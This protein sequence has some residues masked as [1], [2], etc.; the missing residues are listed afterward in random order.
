[1]PGDT[2]EPFAGWA[3]DPDL[4]AAG[5][6]YRAER[7]AEAAAYE[8]LAA[9]DR[10]R[11]RSLADVAAEA[12][13]RGD[14]VAVALTGR[15]FTGTVTHAAG[16]LA[17]MRTTVG[18]DVDVHLAGLVAVRVVQA[19]R[20]GGRSRGPGPASFAARLGEHEAAGTLLEVGARVPEGGLVGRIQAVG[21]DHAVITDREGGAWF[22]ARR[23]IDYVLPRRS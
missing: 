13:A 7:R 9:R 23:A 10:L 2:E 17:C 3:R 15:T 21:V 18:D 14:V 16:D 12:L 6:A 22:V 5:A 4:A 19:M 1:M 8:E 20:A 11:G